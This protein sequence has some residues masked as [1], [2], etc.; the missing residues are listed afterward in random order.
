MIA[1]NSNTLGNETVS[2]RH[3]YGFDVYPGRANR[4][5]P[6]MMPAD[7]VRLI[8]DLPELELYRGDTG[9]I[10]SAWFYPNTAFEVEFA[11]R[12]EST[13]SRVLLLR[14]QIEPECGSNAGSGFIERE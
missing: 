4:P 1:V 10:R 12:S 9:V 8:E 14:E 7:R 6:G 5:T 11:A 3:S 2:G 13:P